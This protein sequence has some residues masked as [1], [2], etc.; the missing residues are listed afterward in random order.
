M[1]LLSFLEFDVNR[2][3]LKECFLNQIDRMMDCEGDGDKLHV[4]MRL[5]RM[6]RVFNLFRATVVRECW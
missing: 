6:N 1:I 2:L 3:A 5:H 4:I